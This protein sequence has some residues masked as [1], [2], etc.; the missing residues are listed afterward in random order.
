M[1]AET[2]L[3]TYG[4]LVP[5]QVNEGQLAGLTGTWSTGVVRGHLHED[6]WGAAHGCPGIRL[7]PDGPEVAVHLFTSADLPAHWGRLDAFEGDGYRRITTLA[8]TQDG[9]VEVSIYELA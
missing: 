6:G 4:T 1:S 3:A 5:G 9:P 8:E 2:R 7:D